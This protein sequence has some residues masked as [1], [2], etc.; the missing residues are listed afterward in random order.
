MPPTGADP[1]AGATGGPGAASHGDKRPADDFTA[2]DVKQL[3]EQKQREG[4][5][6][7]AMSQAEMLAAINEIQKTKI[8]RV[9]SSTG[10]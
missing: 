6:P 1:A 10:C 8:R 5:E 9:E 4:G 3:R 7:I 2:E